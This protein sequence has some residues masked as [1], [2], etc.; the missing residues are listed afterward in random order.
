MH[1]QEIGGFQRAGTG[2]NKKF[3]STSILAW[4]GKGMK[5]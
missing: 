2:K 5:S 3:P 1:H 4:K